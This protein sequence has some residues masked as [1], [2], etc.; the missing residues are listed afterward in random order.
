V[1]KPGSIASRKSVSSDATSR[2]T[3]LGTPSSIFSDAAP[4]ADFRI[5]PR[6]S[7]SGDVQVQLRRTKEMEE[8]WVAWRDKIEREFT[9]R[10]IDM[11]LTVKRVEAEV[12][13]LTM[14]TKAK[15]SSVENQIFDMQDRV[16]HLVLEQQEAEA[17]SE[18][19]EEDNRV[20]DHAD[21]DAR[22]ARLRSEFQEECVEH[23][24][25]LGRLEQVAESLEESLEDSS[26]YVDKDTFRESLA[27]EMSARFEELGEVL[28]DKQLARS[29]H[30][31]KFEVMV[32]KVDLQSLAF[33]ELHRCLVRSPMTQLCTGALRVPDV[34]W[35]KDHAVQ[36]LARV[37]APDERH[38][39]ARV[40]GA[41]LATRGDLQ[42]RAAIMA[43][44]ATVSTVTV[45]VTRA[46]LAAAATVATAVASVAMDSA[47]SDDSSPL[48]VKALASSLAKSAGNAIWAGWDQSALVCDNFDGFLLR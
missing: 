1:Q 41:V 42:A 12:R 21:I 11:G 15:F 44:V 47:R 30:L 36:G 33:L 9:T 2:P 26:K 8:R 18:I 19:K 22:L 39:K 10:H 31:A 20:R 24:E 7:V 43:T 17:R 28:V 14:Y 32:R 46:T 40:P 25:R 37:L 13:S 5:S 38:D 6:N 34:R 45:G 27:T 16:Q 4:R 48:A 3:G 23:V 29:Q 35:F